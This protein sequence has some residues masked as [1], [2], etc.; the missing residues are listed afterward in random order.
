MN[1]SNSI[2]WGDAIGVLRRA[3]GLT[4]E[5]LATAARLDPTEL[6]ALERGEGTTSDR[7]R[8]LD[9]LGYPARLADRRDPLADAEVIRD[10]VEG[11]PWT[12]ATTPAT[13]G[14]A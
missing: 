13:G 8:V 1:G 11:H 5:Q 7:F 10:I 3:H 2:S 4:V 9:A 14:N 6:E 12:W